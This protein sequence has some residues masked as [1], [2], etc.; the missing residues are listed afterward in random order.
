MK[1]K[2]GKD[3]NIKKRRAV[4]ALKDEPKPKNGPKKGPKKKPLPRTPQP[5]AY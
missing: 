2:K 3:I 4:L 1:N 5:P